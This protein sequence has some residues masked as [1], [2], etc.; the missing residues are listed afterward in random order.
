MA[1]KLYYSPGA[2]SLSPHIVLNEVGL[3]FEKVKVDVRA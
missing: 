2:C 3:P 1:M